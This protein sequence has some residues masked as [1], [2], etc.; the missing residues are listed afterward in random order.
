MIPGRMPGGHTA[1][2]QS[3]SIG[4]SYPFLPRLQPAIMMPWAKVACRS[5]I[6]HCVITFRQVAV[7]LAIIREKASTDAPQALSCPECAPPHRD[8][9]VKGASCTRLCKVATCLH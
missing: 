2:G 1:P 5:V 4:L 8:E 6:A 3:I 9:G 7:T